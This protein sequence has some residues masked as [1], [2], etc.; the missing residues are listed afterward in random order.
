M[1]VS[2]ETHPSALFFMGGDRGAKTV[3]KARTKPKGGR[4]FVC[5]SFSLLVSRN[6]S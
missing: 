3:S 2:Q 5:I 6:L 4:A 1:E